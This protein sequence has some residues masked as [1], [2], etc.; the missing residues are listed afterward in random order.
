MSFNKTEQPN[1]II[2]YSNQLPDVDS[3]SISD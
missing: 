1:R 3:F 2:T